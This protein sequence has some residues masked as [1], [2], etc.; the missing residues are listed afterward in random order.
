LSFKNSHTIKISSIEK[1]C[2][3]IET[4][5]FVVAV[6]SSQIQIAKAKG[7]KNFSSNSPLGIRFF[8]S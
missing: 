1:E 2:V 4:T 3:A 5:P 7:V 8:P 6:P